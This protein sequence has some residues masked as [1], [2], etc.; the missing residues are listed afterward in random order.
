MICKFILFLSRSDK[1]QLLGSCSV[2]SLSVQVGQ[3]STSLY[4]D[5]VAWPFWTVICGLSSEVWSGAMLQ[6]RLKA[7]SLAPHRTAR[8]SSQ[9][10]PELLLPDDSKLRNQWRTSVCFA[11]GV[12]GS[13]VSWATNELKNNRLS[14]SVSS[15]TID[16]QLHA[17]DP[18]WIWG[19][20]DFRWQRA[21]EIEQCARHLSQGKAWAGLVS[22][23][24]HSS[25]EVL[26]TGFQ[27][28][29]II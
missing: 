20:Y 4:C 23:L 27:N 12:H 29:N 15:V 16:A 13:S 14:A 7:S 1:W 21:E 25:W 5:A 24:Y 2:S 22:F 6:T 28:C 10:A 9:V 3:C 26:W 18:V 11:V 8:R 17:A 19:H